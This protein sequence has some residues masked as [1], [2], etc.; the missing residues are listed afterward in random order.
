MVQSQF[1]KRNIKNKLEQ[2]TNL[3][4]ASLFVGTVLVHIQSCG[5]ILGT[6]ESRKT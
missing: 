3:L 5:S 6:Q 4:Q 2:P 1:L